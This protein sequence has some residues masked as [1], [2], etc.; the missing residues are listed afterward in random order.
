[1]RFPYQL[2][3][4]KKY[5]TKQV[6]FYEKDIIRLENKMKEG[7]VPEEGISFVKEEVDFMKK[8]FKFHEKELKKTEKKLAKRKKEPVSYTHL[9][10]PTKA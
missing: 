4:D 10:L 5:H 7:R 3:E 9:T 8:R 2:K 6:N 1:M